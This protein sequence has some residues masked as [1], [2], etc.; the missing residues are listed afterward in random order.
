MEILIRAYI[1]DLPFHNLQQ[2]WVKQQT[3]QQAYYIF[4]FS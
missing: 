3:P 1:N 4:F 2:P